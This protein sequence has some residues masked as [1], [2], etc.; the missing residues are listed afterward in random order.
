MK[1]LLTRTVTLIRDTLSGRRRLARYGDPEAHRRGAYN[2]DSAIVN[3]YIPSNGVPPMGG[4][5]M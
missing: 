3:H 1:N 2:P 4:P 5:G